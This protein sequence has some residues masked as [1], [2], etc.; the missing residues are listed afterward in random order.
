VV[1]TSTVIFLVT[2]C[3]LHCRSVKSGFINQSTDEY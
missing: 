2:Y 3:L 1:G